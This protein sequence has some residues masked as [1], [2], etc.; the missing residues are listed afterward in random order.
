MIIHVPIF[1]LSKVL[2]TLTSAII[3]LDL[4]DKKKITDSIETPLYNYQSHYVPLEG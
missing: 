4:L 2:A 3:A 1:H